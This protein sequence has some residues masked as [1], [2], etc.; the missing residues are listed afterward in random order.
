MNLLAFKI[1]MGQSF[2]DALC[3]ALGV[4][5]VRAFHF[6]VSS[7]TNTEYDAGRSCEKKDVGFP[8]P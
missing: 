5:T 6:F 7:N 8:V 3:S 4:L 2:R 1:G